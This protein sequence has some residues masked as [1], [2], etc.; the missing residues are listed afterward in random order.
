MKRRTVLAGTGTA[1]FS[2]VAGC[3]SSSVEPKGYPEI[4]EPLTRERVVDFVKEYETAEH[5]N[6]ILENESRVD[7]INV[8]CDAVFDREVKS[9][10]YVITNC[11]GSAT[12]EPLFGS[13][14]V[15]HYETY[16]PT[17]RV[18][19][20]H[21]QRAEVDRDVRQGA[22]YVFRMLNFAATEHELFLTVT[23]HTD[24]KE[25]QIRASEY[26]LDGETGVER[27][28]DLTVGTEYE[29]AVELNDG[30]HSETV[31]WDSETFKWDVQDQSRGVGIYVT[32]YRTIEIGP[33][34]RE[35]PV[36]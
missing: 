6:Y 35:G 3:L 19:E 12:H 13:A 20:Q 14:S 24:S 11:G 26:A 21:V 29:L 16:A 30:D 25:K 23:P 33:L 18:N 17:Y 10:F 28:F 4:P 9:T 27:R 1:L 34:P 22:D 32:R 15:G 2:S 5:H 31:N 8:V 7:S 36:S